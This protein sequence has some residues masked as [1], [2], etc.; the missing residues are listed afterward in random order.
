MKLTIRELK[1]IIKCS[2]GGSEPNEA[3]DKDLVD[4]PAF[5]KESLHVSQKR[6]K[7]IKTFL[8]DMGLTSKK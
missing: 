2:I 6:K 8:N 3:F 7:K 5:D 4:D 1:K